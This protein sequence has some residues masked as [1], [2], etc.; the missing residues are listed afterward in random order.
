MQK[1]KKSTA[2]INLFEELN[3]VPNVFTM[4]ASFAGQNYV[5]IL[6]DY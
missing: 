6:Y 4:E 1:S 3:D 2:R 5:S